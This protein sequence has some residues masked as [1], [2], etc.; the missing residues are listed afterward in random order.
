[1]AVY[2][3]LVFHFLWKISSRDFHFTTSVFDLRHAKDVYGHEKG[4]KKLQNSCHKVVKF[5]DLLEHLL[6]SLEN[7]LAVT[8]TKFS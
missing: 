4:R 6:R 2:A 8:Q 1:M 5:L 7:S 3:Y